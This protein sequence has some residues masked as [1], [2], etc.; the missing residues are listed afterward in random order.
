MESRR[1]DK[2]VICG[3]THELVSHKLSGDHVISNNRE[4]IIIGG[5]CIGG[6]LLFLFW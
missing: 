4:W 6:A 1:R 5:E 2:S 3:D